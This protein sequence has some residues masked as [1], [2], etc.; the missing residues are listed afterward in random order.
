MRTG[1]PTICPLCGR[2]LGARLEDHHL[3]PKAFKGRETVALHPICH[4]KIHSVLTERELKDHFHSLERLRE[5]PDIAAF[6]TWIAGKHAD[7][8]GPTR[9]SRALKEKRAARRR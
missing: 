5:H 9:A 8:H 7:F 2:P 6:V 3:V 4:R 1:A